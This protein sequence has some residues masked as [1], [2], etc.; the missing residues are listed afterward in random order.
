[1]WR[2]NSQRRTT[3]RRK[4][5]TVIRPE[6]RAIERSIC[7]RSSGNIHRIVLS[8]GAPGDAEDLAKVDIAKSATQPSGSPTQNP[9]FCS[10]H[11]RRPTSA[12]GEFQPSSPKTEGEEGGRTMTMGSEHNAASGLHALLLPH[13][14]ELVPH[15]IALVR[16]RQSCSVHVGC[17]LLRFPAVRAPRTAPAAATALGRIPHRHRAGTLPCATDPIRSRVRG[18]VTRVRD[19][20]YPT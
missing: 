9:S 1:V 7:I 14:L 16:L 8:R 10:A 3:I 17:A 13:K 18:G 11:S 6:L 12:A 15:I 4:R 19:G 2:F 20:D 5:G